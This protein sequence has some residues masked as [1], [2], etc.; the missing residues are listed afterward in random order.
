MQ[1]HPIPTGF[2]PR[3]RLSTNGDWMMH[4]V[5]DANDANDAT[6]ATDANAATA[7]NDASSFNWAN[8]NREYYIEA[9]K[10]LVNNLTKL[11]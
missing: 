5:N 2:K 3:G 1:V 9:A 4:C 11:V 10:K 7:A 8:L 6:A